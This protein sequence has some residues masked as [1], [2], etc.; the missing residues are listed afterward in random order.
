MNIVIRTPK[1]GVILDVHLFR[2][3]VS[4]I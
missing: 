2:E 3:I 1:H 4:G